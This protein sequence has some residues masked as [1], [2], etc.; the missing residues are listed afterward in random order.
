MKTKLKRV[1]IRMQLSS[2]SMHIKHLVKIIIIAFCSFF[3]QICYAQFVP[4][5]QYYN[6]P[7]LTNPSQAGISDHTQLMIQY[8]RSRVSNYEI[9]SFSFVRPFYRGNGF[10]AGGMGLTLISQKAGPGGAYRVL[11]ATATFA[12]NIYLSKNQ[13]ISAGLQGGILNKKLDPSD[14]TTDSQYNLGVFDP[15]L[16]TGEN[17]SYAS[18]ARLVIN[19]GFSWTMTDHEG[20]QKVTLGVA[21]SNMNKPSFDVLSENN[22]EKLTYTVTGEMLIYQRGRASIH[23]TFRYLTSGSGLANIGAQVRYKLPDANS[24]VMIGAWYKTSKGMTAAIQYAS[25]RYVLAASTDLSVATDVQVNAQ[26]AIELSL[27]WRLKR[28]GNMKRSPATRE[29]ISETM[30]PE[31]ALE[32]D[33]VT[34]SEQPIEQEEP[35]ETP[36]QIAIQQPVLSEDTEVITPEERRT[37]EVKIP[38]SLG[39]SELT[40]ESLAFIENRLVPVLKNHPEFTLHI[41]GHSCTTGDRAINEKISLE[42]AQSIRKVLIGYGVPENRVVATGMD[43]QKPIASNDTEEGRQKN[44]RVEFELIRL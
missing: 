13:Y 22:A 7:L 39:S 37:L 38:F 44:R 26:N 42:R 9:P 28:K 8:R 10:R 40:P 18:E 16:Q 36:Q 35:M 25:E 30:Q 43:F 6:V 21:F 24:N 27:G 3:S 19:S 31:P 23:P 2:S 15:S 32:L 12:Y 17:M 33:P 29:T 4:Y 5:S 34:E 20:I 14:L 11:G 1:P 41:T